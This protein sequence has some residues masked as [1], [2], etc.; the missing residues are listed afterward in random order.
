MARSPLERAAGVGDFITI[1]GKVYECSAVTVN[2]LGKLHAY[3]RSRVADPLQELTADL[4][5]FGKF[6]PEVQK[7]LAVRAL[8]I[9][10]QNKTNMLRVPIAEWGDNVEGATFLFWMLVR[11]TTPAF[12]TLEAVREAFPPEDEDRQL[13]PAECELIYQTVHKLVFGNKPPADADPAAKKKR[14]AKLL[15]RKR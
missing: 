2:M 7:A 6:P 4:E 11:K 8:E 13:Q 14:R 15:R 5:T 12:A 9:R 3:L 10:E 1:R